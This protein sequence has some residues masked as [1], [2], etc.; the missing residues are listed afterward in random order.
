[1]SDN[2]DK[3]ETLDD[4]FDIER[5]NAR[6]E[7]DYKAELAKRYQ[8]QFGH[9]IPF[10]LLPE[11]VSEEVIF[12]KVKCCLETGKDNLTEL[13]ECFIDKDALY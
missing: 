5:G 11:T 9:A 2:S 1:M 12:E 8:E 13:F 3:Y 10:Y 7:I 4:L 6:F